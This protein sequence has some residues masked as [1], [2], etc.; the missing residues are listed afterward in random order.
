MTGSCNKITLDRYANPKSSKLYP[1]KYYFS[2]QYRRLLRWFDDFGLP[3]IIGLPL[4]LILFLGFSLL[5]LSK[6]DYIPWIYGL[7]AIFY[8]TQWADTDHQI[9]LNRLFKKSE[10]NKIRIVENLLITAP[11]IIALLIDQQ[12]LVVAL[13]IFLAMTTVVVPYSRIPQPS[14][15][16]PF[17]NR[18]FEL[19]QG[20]RSYWPYHLIQYSI[21]LIGLNVAN[22]NLVL[23]MIGSIYISVFSYYKKPEH[24]KLIW[25]HDID[26]YQFIK[27]KITNAIIGSSLLVLPI[28]ILSIIYFNNLLLPVLLIMLIGCILLSMIILA[29]Y[30]AYPRSIN[31][32]QG[33][34]ICICIVFPPLILFVLPLFYRKSINAIK[35][36]LE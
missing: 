33:I 23:V 26:S 27:L 36:I 20:F 35:P 32:V 8:C 22:Q 4:A 13:L 34:L 30:S 5:L 12:Y 14:I 31:I 21:A 17:R 2:L 18:P 29:K 25:I 3:P 15:P 6:E 16:T 19:S 1:L 10:A 24:S 11:F 28:G 7:C 9:F